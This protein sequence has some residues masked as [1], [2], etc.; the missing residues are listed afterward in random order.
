MK[1]TIFIFILLC[2][3]GINFSASAEELQ[4][5]TSINVVK[6]DPELIKLPQIK[7]VDDNLYNQKIEDDN[8]EY[9]KNKKE[10]GDVNFELYKILDRLLRANNLQ[11]QN[12]RITFVMD[13][14]E[15]NA[16]ANAYNLISVSSALYDSLYPNEDAI[17]FI[18]AHELSHHILGHQQY[19]IER[20]H[21][22]NELEEKIKDAIDEAYRQRR[23]G[24][25]YSALGNDYS[26]LTSSITNTAIV[27]SVETMKKNLNKE[28]ELMRQMEHAADIEA[29]ILMTKAN[30][31]TTNALEAMELVAELPNIYTNR[32]THPNAQARLKIIK[33]QI[34]LIN[35]DE[36]NQQGKF[37]LYNSKVLAVKKTTDKKA[38]VLSRDENIT[39]TKYYSET[40]DSKLS[41]KGYI[42]YKND[43]LESAQSN[44][45][46]AFKINSSD[47]V[48]ALYLSYI[49]ECLY[50]K[51]HDKKTLK[52]AKYW[53][54]KAYKIEQNKNTTKQKEDLSSLYKDTD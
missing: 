54:N 44:F 11:Y 22:I 20:L 2:L 28:Y 41:K 3:F 35:E 43:E 16:Y 12:W 52:K 4:A 1:K 23:M 49:N 9:Q 5:Q 34:D 51:N 31:D 47:Y 45:T 24:S 8:K 50:N 15:L 10:T 33:E 37:N 13:P 7:N 30:Y 42:D 48:S 21:K 18:I 32:N 38:L 17:A 36:L 14:E 25:F 40:Q 39:K 27:I 19:Q 29:V 26:S 53:A 6:K 46:K